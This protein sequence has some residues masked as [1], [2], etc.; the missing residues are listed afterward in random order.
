MNMNNFI[1]YV[2][3]NIRLKQPN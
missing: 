2:R 1:I 3:M